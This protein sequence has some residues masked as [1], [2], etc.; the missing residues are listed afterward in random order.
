VAG[1]PEL[2]FLGVAGFAPQDVFLK[3][4][5]SAQQLF[6]RRFGTRGRSMVLVNNVQT[7]ATVPLAG[8]RN[9]Q[10][11]LTGIARK[12]D[13]E[14]DVLFLFLTSHGGADEF[15]IEYPPLPLSNLTAE[16]LRAMLDRA[17]VKWRVIV[18]SAC[19]SG[20]FIPALE[21]KQTLVVT[22]AAADRSSFG[23]SSENDFTYF[24]D[25]YI[26]HALE[27][28]NSFIDGFEEARR[29]I[30]QREHAERLTPSEPQI[31]VGAAIRAKLATL[32]PG[33]GPP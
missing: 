33:F 30:A 18:I 5:R 1:P 14:R 32:E 15:A 27:H 20:S 11:A 19:Y 16:E 10:A 3:E 17:G 4:I 9:L 25:A 31:Y 7:A 12:M 24:G 28:Q 22:A 6:D 8:L 26:G 29:S 23:C 13:V 2:Y 21:D